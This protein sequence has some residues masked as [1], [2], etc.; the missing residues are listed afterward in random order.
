M[1]VDVTSRYRSLTPIDAP[2]ALGAIHPTIPARLRPN[3]PG[4]SAGTQATPYFHTVVAGDTLELLAYRYLGSSR[5]WWQLA[6]ANPG[7]FPLELL[8]GS[9]IRIPSQ[10]DPGLVVRTRTF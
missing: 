1:A 7:V 5:A 3:R 10:V 6:D 8:P 4:P 2:D 9:S